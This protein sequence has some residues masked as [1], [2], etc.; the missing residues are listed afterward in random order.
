MEEEIILTGGRVTKGVV[1]KGNLVYR[2]CCNNSEFVHNILLWL[3]KKDKSISP[4]FMGISDDGREIITFLDG[5]SPDNLGDFNDEQLL[6]AGKLIKRLHNL[7]YDFPGCINGQTVCHYDLSPCNFMFLNN[8][9][10]AVFDW[11]SA[12][13][14]DPR[15]DFAYAVQMWCDIGNPEQTVDMVNWKIKKMIQGYVIKEF[16]LENRII[17][18][19]DR[20]YNS[21]FETEIQTENFKWWIRECKKWIM[22]NKEIFDNIF[23]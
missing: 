9:P 23:E 12:R 4:H 17:G 3:E 1:K 15:D 22:N 18:Q 2:P 16:D 5:F 8:I 21:I 6:E 7:L 19:L 14:G 20:L 10:Y 13:I 11:D